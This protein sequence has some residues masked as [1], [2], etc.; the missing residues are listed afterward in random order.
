M[1]VVSDFYRAKCQSGL[2]NMP[3]KSSQSDLDAEIIFSAPP[4]NVAV[5]VEVKLASAGYHVFSNASVNASFLM[6]H[7]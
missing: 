6:Y 2:G 7:Y 3:V 1:I 4:T 5:T